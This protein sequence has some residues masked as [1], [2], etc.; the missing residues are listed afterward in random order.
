MENV[1]LICLIVLLQLVLKATFITAQEF[2][3]ATGSDNTLSITPAAFDCTNYLVPILGNS[4][5][6]ANIT[7]QLVS[8]SG[9][10][11][12]SRISTGHTGGPPQV[13]F[14]GKNYLIIWTDVY[15]D[16]NIATGSMYG[17]FV[18]TSGNLV[19]Q[20]FVI[21]TGVNSKWGRGTAISYNDTTYLVTYLKGGDKAS[22]L[23][24]QRLSRSGTLIGNPIKITSNYAREAYMAYDGTNY[25][26]AW[27]DRSND[28]KYIYG[29]FLSKNAA[30]I[31][32]N[33]MIDDG[34]NLSDNPVTVTF[35]GSRYLVTLH[36]QAPNSKW[37]LFARFVAPSGIV[38]PNRI[39][40]REYTKSP[41]YP[42]A[43]FDGTNYLIT[44]VDDA[45]S[46]HSIIRGRFFST[47][48]IPID[49]EF[50]VF[51]TLGGKAPLVVTPTYGNNKY[52][53]V[54]TRLDSTSFNNGD[55][56]GK[57]I[58]KIPG[59]K[60]Q[61]YNS[62]ANTVLLDH[63]DGATS[64]NILAYRENFAPCGTAKQSVT[65]SYSFAEGPIGLNQALSLNAPTGEPLGSATYLKY[66]GEQL[67]SQSNGSI[68]FWVY[69][70]SFGKGTAPFVDQGPYIGS[71]AGWTFY[72]TIDSTG[73]LRAGAWAA[74][75]MTS[76]SI[77]IPLKTWTHVATT[78]GTSGA[79]LYIN[80][81]LVGSDANTG[82]PAA[83]YGGS[84]LIGLLTA[85][86]TAG[87]IDELRISNVQRSTFNVTSSEENTQIPNG[88]FEVWENYPD[89]MNPNNV[90]QKPDKWIGS[91]PK[92]PLTYSFSIEKNIDSY[93]IGTGQYS[94]IIKNDNPNGVPG[95]A[96]SYDVPPKVDLKVIKPPSFPINFRPKFLCL[97]YKY[98][99]V[100]VDTMM[101]G[102]SFFKNGVSIGDAT[103]MTS[104]NVSNWTSLKI[105]VTFYTTDVPD[106]ATIFLTTSRYVRQD[107]SKL[108]VDNLSF[109]NLITSIS[110]T[111]KELP[112]KFNLEQNYPNP[113]N[114]V[115]TIEFSIP[116][117][118]FVNLE[119]FNILG[120]KITT[121]VNEEKLP[122]SYKVKFDCRNLSSGIYFYRISTPKFTSVKKLLLMK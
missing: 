40:I 27:V 29:Q 119:V 38:D 49:N 70:T 112:S 91:L 52:L 68:E 75:T 16:K 111:T 10:L 47:S 115:T 50:I 20:S 1:K 34:P 25:L 51:N 24:G 69:F 114:P 46:S 92:S 95:V 89:D 88:G 6:Q 23:Y 22:Y 11:V 82:M 74:F 73:Q 4:Q 122:G 45:F 58:N 2:P 84:L 85:A 65:P 60:I 80:G 103:Y 98:L 17:Q 21:V 105:P 59:L 56:Y 39:T 55:V 57:F 72:M 120:Q 35:D 97:Y 104:Q 31:G 64:A 36:E 101:V 81:L 42:F 93:P 121:L 5:N 62:D 26:I 86:G 96:M 7:A 33:F 19:G 48:G 108:Y 13:A 12:G 113:F 28:D 77:K 54:T 9:A 61:P 94:M 78:W 90:Y 118:S 110:L 102:C 43:A 14:D 41:G 32:S 53:V 117:N 100:H 66:P 18:N 37:N 107:G 109:D 15:D 8:S 106:S 76:G 44:W 63:F 87:S 67:L 3:I 71:C 83:G 116:Q 99:P 79:K 30:L